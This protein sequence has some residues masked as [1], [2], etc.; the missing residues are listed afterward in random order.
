[1]ITVHIILFFLFKATNIKII[2]AQHTIL[3]NLYNTF[4]IFNLSLFKAMRI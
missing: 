2:T 1:M 3:Y 4:I